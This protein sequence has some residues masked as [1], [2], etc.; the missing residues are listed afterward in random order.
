[1]NKQILIALGIFA[2]AF[3]FVFPTWQYIE[4]KLDVTSVSVNGQQVDFSIDYAADWPKSCY[5]VVYGPFAFD[6]SGHEKGNNIFVLS[7]R[8][9][10]LSDSLL[11]QAGSGL[12]QFKTEL[13]CDNDMI[14]QK[15][16]DI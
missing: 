6:E 13:W 8:E 9:G 15:I 12:T 4:P 7:S 3:L 14:L 11:L 2:L 1:M 10:T 16:Q 5:I